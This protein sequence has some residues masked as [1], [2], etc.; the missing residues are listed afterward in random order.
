MP[1]GKVVV[2]DAGP[3][4]GLSRVGGLRLLPV[5]FADI[6]VTETV[7]NECLARPDRPEAAEI[8][9]ALDAGWMS[10]H[11][12]AANA[13]DW[14]LGLGETSALALAIELTAGALVDD[15]AARR[16]ATR[17]RIPVIGLLGV[18]ILA[19]RAGAVETIRPLV[20]T[21]VESGY[22]LSSRL[23]EDT[24]MRVGE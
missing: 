12:E 17:L 6:L 8:E 5:L 22:F 16:V 24:L 20:D 11:A 18:L 14:G 1:S 3:L 21:L 19:K 4:I 23:I 15:R 2:A 13:A 7:L 10:R 9:G